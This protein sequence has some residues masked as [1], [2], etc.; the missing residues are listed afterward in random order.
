MNKTLRIRLVPGVCALLNAFCLGL[1]I[2]GND[3]PIVIVWDLF[4][5]GL[6]VFLA[7]S[8]PVEAAP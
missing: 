1:A 8:R 2:G 4:S 6:C 5:V 7:A 3:W